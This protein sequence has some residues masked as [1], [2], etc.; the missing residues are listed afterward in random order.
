[1]HVESFADSRGD[2]GR[3]LAAMLQQQQAVVQQLV[4]GGLGN[5]ADNSTHEL[6]FSR[7][8]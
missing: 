6:L 4:Y 7:I 8:G 3:V 5:D 1:V 2:S